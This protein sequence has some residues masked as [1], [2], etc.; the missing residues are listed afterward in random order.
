VD[1][2]DTMASVTSLGIHKPSALP[3]LVS[4]GILPSEPPENL[5]EWRSVP[6]HSA[7]KNHERQEE[8]LLITECCVVWSRNGM[9]QRVFRFDVEGEAVT[10]AVF[11]HF[12][13]N[14][15]R[16]SA[17]GAIDEKALCS[18]RVDDLQALGLD[19][20]RHG[21][22]GL[23]QNVETDSRAQYRSGEEPRRVDGSSG[24]DDPENSKAAR[25]RALVVIFTTQAHIFFLSGTSH[26]VHLP[27]EVDGAFPLPHGIL[28]QRRVSQY[29]NVPEK[30]SL[31]SVPPNSF[32]H[33]QLGSSLL[34]P[35]SQG[36]SSLADLQ[37]NP[38]IKD[39]LLP[40]LST[41]LQQ[42]HTSNDDAG[43]PRL[44]CLTDPL[45][46]IGTVVT[47]DRGRV[48]RTSLLRSGLAGTLLDTIDPRETLLYVS[49]DDELGE[50]TDH[51]KGGAP[52][53]LAVTQHQE[54]RSLTI[55]SVEQ[56]AEV[57]SIRSQRR[58][59]SGS[60]GNVSR[61]RSS[62]G[63]GASTGANTPIARTVSMGRESF[64]S[65]KSRLA[66]SKDVLSDD[67]FNDSDRDLVS[68]LDSALENPKA[69]LKASRRVSSLL[70]RADLSSSH[71]KTAFSD[72]VSG[73]PAGNVTRRG[74]SFGSHGMRLSSGL[75][76]GTAL[77]RS[78]ASFGVRSSIEPPLVVVPPHEEM[79]ED[80]DDDDD[81]GGKSVSPSHNLRGLRKEVIMS[82]IHTVLHDDSY[83]TP[84]TISKVF[85]LR[86]PNHCIRTKAHQRHC[87]VCLM[88]PDAGTLTT[89]EIE[90]IDNAPTVGSTKQGKRDQ[91]S[92]NAA[93]TR[94]IRV[95]DSKQNSGL[96]DACKVRNGGCSR[97][98]T[99]RDY[100]DGGSG[101]A[102][103]APWAP[104]VSI[105]LP[106]KLN[107]YD[108]YRIA[109]GVSLKQKRE[110]G[111]KRVLSQGPSRLAK[112][113]HDGQTGMA[114]VVD[115]EG[116]KHRIE[117]QLTP[118]NTLVRKMILLCDSVLPDIT[119]SGDC[120]LILWWSAM[121]WLRSQP[122]DELDMEW[123][124]FVLVLFSIAVGFIEDRRSETTSRQKRKGGLLRSSS[125]VNTNLESWEAM[126]T[127]ERS[128][129]GVSPMWM[130][131]EA[132]Q[133][134]TKQNSTSVQSR[135][136]SST[137]ARSSRPTTTALP[138]QK[139]CPYL[140]HCLS[141]ARGFRLS[142][143]ESP[144]AQEGLLSTAATIGNARMMLATLLIGLHLLR[145]ELKLENM[146]SDA[147]HGITPMLAQLGGWLGWPTWGFK[148]TAVYVLESTNMAS[149]LFDDSVIHGDGTPAEP[150]Q[151]PSIL[152]SIEST[153]LDAVRRPFITLLDLVGGS[154]SSD[155]LLFAESTSSRQLMN[156]TPRTIMITSLLTSRSKKGMLERLDEMSSW[157]LNLSILE[158]LPESVAVPFRA[159]MSFCQAQPSPALGKHMLEM[160]GRDDLNLLDEEGQASK[161]Q[162]RSATAP[163]KEIMRDIHTICNSTLEVETVG[164]YDGAAEIDRHS[165]TRMVYK[166]DQRFAEATK[167]LHPLNAPI[168]QCVP[169]PEWSDTELLEAQQEL[170]KTIAVRTLSVSPGRS[171]LFYSAR[172][173]LLTE[174][175]P[176]HGFTLS[177]VMRPSNT[178]VTA[179]KLVYTEDK[180][181]WAFFHAGVE[182]GLSIA[183]N[184]KGID[185]S[186][187]LF[188]KPQELKNRHAGFLLALGLNGH[189][190]SIA[191]WV[192][193]K[194]LTPKHTMTSIGLL[195]GLAASYLGTM[196]TLIT[197]LLSVHVTRMLPPGA[198]EL[199]LSPLT[200]TS[201]IMGIGL[202]YCNTQHRRMSE[203]MLS[204]ME[205]VDEEDPS[206][207]QDGL[208]DEGY[209]LAAG[210]AL[211]FINLG[212]GKD[213]KGLHDMHIVERLL[214]LA[215]GTRKVSLVHILDKGTAAAAV[216][217]ALIFMKT[218]DAVL[219]RKIDVPDTIHQFDY[220]RPDVFLL[221]TV[222]RHLIMWD[223]IRASFGWMKNQLPA[224]F[225]YKTKL[226]SL[227]SL[228]SEDMPF[229]NIVTGLCLSIGLRFAGTGSSEVRA[230]LCHYLDQ[231]IR[232]CRFPVL[233]YDSKLA[234]TTVRNC[235]DVVALAA[236]CVM[237]GT[238]D[239]HLFRRLR[240]LHGRT[241]V[242][243][244][245]G[246]HLAAH[247]AIG[248]LFLGG[249]T[250]TFSTSNLAIASLL[251]AFYPLFPTTVLDNK[252]HLQAF[253]HFWVLAAEP[254][255]LVIYEV[256]T[257]RLVPL[258]I[259]VTLKDDSELPMT[260]P[261]LLPEL[262]TI[263]KIHTNDPEYWRVTLDLAGN[264]AHL[265]AFKCHQSI[266][267]R[268]RAAYDAHTSLFSATMQAL[269]DTQSA[270]RLGRQI[271]EWVFT[272]PT[273]AN[274]DRAERALVL[275]PDSASAVYKTTRGTVVDDRLVLET[276]CLDS[277]KSERLWNLRL[278]FAW[279][280]EVGREGGQW[281][282]LG[283]EV[284]EKLKA[285][286]VMRKRGQVS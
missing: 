269:N 11:T 74:A 251:C 236:A 232:I 15:E 126:L 35:S 183:R 18:D 40:M 17:P 133:W 249:G 198:A 264:P 142:I 118:H 211:G 197:R 193:F 218:Q 85:V 146:A 176:I 59:P 230:L 267:V 48:T 234:R 12:L 157:G 199:N 196:D 191:K 68:H 143:H 151:P 34:L 204:E 195:L 177:C 263:A 33:Y 97:M 43:L 160:I 20:E 147:L 258:A 241:E 247:L 184:A 89:I 10:E 7:R 281:G 182:A 84:N 203:I 145:E 136:T 216:A 13:V 181:S 233:N 274:F 101:L 32:A 42:A 61:R 77:P 272:L 78:R 4:E 180:V 99:L 239:L 138:S 253:R 171:C 16:V 116:T 1:N 69:T 219:A 21:P 39:P 155:T 130:E 65:T 238:G 152:Q 108:P 95:V 265:Q 36:Q 200:Q 81:K 221:R 231:F 268:R 278:L 153:T 252:S 72:L 26:V 107:V 54:T 270:H 210:F 185:T 28:L 277:G 92:E 175:F 237:A 228:N 166:E 106:K 113:E 208:R 188:N 209:R 217:I 282:W 67:S 64:G 178:T 24:R 122:E 37:D 202:L 194:Y 60:S 244:P 283:R 112:F 55:W 165:V 134:T 256:D 242:D 124:A 240:A 189:L 75:N 76:T 271:F 104:S 224:V 257:H 149:W 248:I 91:S 27:F 150:F 87:F 23:E 73:H 156:L 14:A 30:P 129:S 29:P 94:N 276:A 246:S 49:A 44:Y 114:D 168:A 206:N 100:A 161:T 266:Y 63:P 162:G 62:Y 82:T 45:A 170:A 127:E 286:L 163:V 120:I 119:K 172:L 235:Q 22:A 103:Q 229:F 135:E 212:R 179:D 223:D 201:G 8:E 86:S 254:R 169:E 205:N 207:P 262:P 25:S 46:E 261:C 280:E 110:G 90:I 128:M 132:W 121:S 260:A 56:V 41:I 19:A 154:E 173:P 6:D 144:I 79:L 131:G 285:R 167:L 31:P 186:W 9:V 98:L 57:S 2:G 174:K 50:S 3:F 137:R 141:L 215:V 255:C 96:T 140:I 279:A 159:A 148:H 227:R 80:S 158:T 53:V 125:G 102:L 222:A 47:H 187:I 220:V 5:Y 250:H 58:V 225:Q 259:T 213:L 214:A 105:H 111:F 88:N 66:P 275:P 123:T 284:V 243:I 192:A 164:A 117:I 226:T 51:S 109:S 38:D 52:L 83:H 190:K 70:A 115:A 245:Y 93:G 71:D 273:F 139:K